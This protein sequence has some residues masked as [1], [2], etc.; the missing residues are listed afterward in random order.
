[1]RADSNRGRRGLGYVV[2]ECFAASLFP[3][4]SHGRTEIFFAPLSRC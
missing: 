2:I 4:L 3:P 1:M